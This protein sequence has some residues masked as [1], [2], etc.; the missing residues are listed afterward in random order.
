[1]A[2]QLHGRQGRPDVFVIFNAHAEWQK[3]ALPAHEGRW[4]WRRLVDTNLAMPEDIVDDKDA[5]PLVPADHYVLAP[6]SAV[7]LLG[8]SP[9]S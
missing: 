3:F 7:I 8:P 2:F 6:R 1:M 9:V 4:R 5:V